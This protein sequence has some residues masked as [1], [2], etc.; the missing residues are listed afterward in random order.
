MTT[1][2]R[3]IPRSPTPLTP[4]Q[5]L[6]K[7]QRVADRAVAAAASAA[8]AAGVADDKAEAAQSDADQALLD[9][10]NAQADADAGIVL[11]TEAGDD[12]A[13]AMLAVDAVVDGTTPFT[14]LNVGGDDKAG[15]LTK[16]AGDVIDTDGI[17]DE[18]VTAVEPDFDPSTTAVTT[19]A[20]TTLASVSVTVVAGETVDLQG[21]VDV[22]ALYS[23]TPAGDVAASISIL[24]YRDS[25]L[26]LTRTTRAIKS[27]V[28][29]LP[30]PTSW[31]DEPAAGAHTYTL[32][33]ATNNITGLSTLNFS[34]PYLTATRIKR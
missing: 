14:G 34:N 3:S 32:R 7:A 33:V 27:V 17:A 15:F 21:I 2:R 8:S 24:L 30:L 26:L 31:T 11:A 19:T 16:V 22:F 13:D 20:E 25:T 4:E 12:A 29:A 10:A 9:A 18:A 1:V 5:R 23:G 6:A 28:I